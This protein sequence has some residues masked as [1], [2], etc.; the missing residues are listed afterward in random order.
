[1]LFILKKIDVIGVGAVFFFIEK[2]RKSLAFFIV[3]DR[4]LVKGFKR[5]SILYSG[6]ML[7]ISV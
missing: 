5:I 2:E 4:L 1:M 6:I 7:K 3:K